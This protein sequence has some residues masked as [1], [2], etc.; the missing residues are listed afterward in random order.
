MQATSCRTK[1][2]DP[3][4]PGDIHHSRNGF[5]DALLCRAA[6]SCPSLP[7]PQDSRDV[8]GESARFCDT[9]ALF[10][11]LAMC[12]LMQGVL[13]AARPLH[14]VMGKSNAFVM[15]GFRF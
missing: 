6:A 3:D 8:V 11:V 5:G 4:W 13:R 14:F 15:R 2:D 9:H 1:S 7:V 12:A 10:Y